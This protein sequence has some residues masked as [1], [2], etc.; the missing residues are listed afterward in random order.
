MP[1][2]WS[3]KNTFVDRSIVDLEDIHKLI[4]LDIAYI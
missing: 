1:Y 4:C 2:F 3:N